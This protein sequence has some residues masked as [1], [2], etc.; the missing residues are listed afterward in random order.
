MKQIQR[1]KFTRESY[2]E[3]KL[4]EAEQNTIALICVIVLVLLIVGIAACYTDNALPCKGVSDSV[5]FDSIAN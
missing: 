3:R 2:H 5:C 4:R 1:T